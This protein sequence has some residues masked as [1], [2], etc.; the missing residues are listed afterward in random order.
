MRTVKKKQNA[1]SSQVAELHAFL[2]SEPKSMC[3][4]APTEEETVIFMKITT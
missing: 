1:L 3:T 4:L 2:S